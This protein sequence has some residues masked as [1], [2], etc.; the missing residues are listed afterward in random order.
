[1]GS[2]AGLVC[3]D[4]GVKSP[5][6]GGGG[7]WISFYST[8]LTTTLSYH[9]TRIRYTPP[10][11]FVNS[12]SPS[13]PRE[14]SFILG[15]TQDILTQNFRPR[16]LPCCLPSSVVISYPIYIILHWYLS[17]DLSTFFFLLLRKTRDCTLLMVL[18][19]SVCFRSI[20]CYTYRTTT[21]YFI[22]GICVSNRF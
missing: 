4:L 5:H 2:C 21:T 18:Y 16:V 22:E 13:V 20:P 7:R 10:P 12:F 14:G 9:F 11:N 8:E 6:R 1:M 19:N 17:I 3:L 15:N